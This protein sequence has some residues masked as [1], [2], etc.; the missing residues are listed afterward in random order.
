MRTARQ[1]SIRRAVLHVLSLMP[2]GILIPDRLLRADAQ[3]SMLPPAPTTAELDA[4]IREADTARLITSLPGEDDTLRK[5]S[6]AGR[7]WLAEHP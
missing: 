7:A 5:L 4:E 1:T 3:R 6:D 2:E